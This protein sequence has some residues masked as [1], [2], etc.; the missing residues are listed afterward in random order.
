MIKNS[1]DPVRVSENDRPYACAVCSCIRAQA[2]RVFALLEHFGSYK[3]ILYAPEKEISAIS[4]NKELAADI[5][6]IGSKDPLKEYETLLNK[7]I[8]LVLHGDDDYPGKLVT[9]PDPPP[10]LFVKGRMPDKE[11]MSV[12]VIGAR[13]CSEYGAHIAR[14]LGEALGREK[15]NLISGM[16]R[17]IDGISQEAALTA[18]G[19]SAGILGCGVDICYP[20]ENRKLYEALIEKGALI[21]TYAPGTEARSILFPPRNR[22]VSGM[23]DAVVV[24]EAR[25][26]SGT[27]ITV[28][29]ALEQGRD[30]YAVPGRITDRT[31]DGCNGLLG[32]GAQV[33]LSPEIFIREITEHRLG[34]SNAKTA[35]RRRK[36]EGSEEAL[37]NLSPEAMHIYSLLDHSPRSVEDIAA[38]AGREYTVSTV[39]L[40]LMQIVINGYAGQ[41]SP[42]VYIKV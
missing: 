3:G 24:I 10:A 12:A 42:G 27:L 8:R 14:A 5:K 9:I 25:Q 39:R 16:A 21:S 11:T 38:M 18:G 26:R 20:S 40:L 7:R 33:F 31:S 37:P 32:Q 15:I 1:F 6:S 41:I 22:I 2:G 23:A 19:Y 35:K 28:D 30:V 34:V 36:F 17:G 13:E 29:M 4:G